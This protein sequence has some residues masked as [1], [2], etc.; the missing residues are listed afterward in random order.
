MLVRAVV[1]IQNF[2]NR[3]N[4]KYELYGPW[5]HWVPSANLRKAADDSVDYTDN[6][7]SSDANE[8][9][10]SPADTSGDSDDSNWQ[11]VFFWKKRKATLHALQTEG[12]MPKDKL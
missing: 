2:V 6:S 1:H 11:Q 7:D 3:R 4:I 12:L 10:H 8:D 5:H 9:S